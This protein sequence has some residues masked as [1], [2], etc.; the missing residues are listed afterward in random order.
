M[1]YASGLVVALAAIVWSAWRAGRGRPRLLLAGEVDTAPQGTPHAPREEGRHAERDE[2]GSYRRVGRLAAL[3]IAAAVGVAILATHAS[4]EFQAAAFFGA[5]SLVLAACLM[6]VR[7]R[8]R[9]GATG[10]AV[11]LGRGNLVRLAMRNAARNPLRSTL[12]IGLVAAASFLIVAVS[13]FRRDPAQEKPDRASGNGGFTIVAESDQPIYHDFST[14][15]GREQ[16]GF[17]AEDS[18][19][20]A[21]TRTIQLRVRPGDDASCLNLYRPQQPRILG[22]PRDFIE[23]G[24]FDWAAVASPER[25]DRHATLVLD[26][27][28]VEPS[29]ASTPADNPWQL[30]SLEGPPDNDG[31]PRV[32]VVLEKTTANYSLHLSGVGQTL[33]IHDGSGRPVRLVIVG[34][35]AASLFQGDLLVSERAFL[36]YFPEQGGFRFFLVETKSDDA[37]QVQNVQR[38]LERTLGDFGLSTQ[39]TSQRLAAFQAVENT[40]LSTFQSLG[41]LGLLLGTFG[42]GAVQLRSVLERRRELALLRA[43]GFR[44]R[45]LAGMVVLENAILLA[46][47]LACGVVSAAVAVLPHL[48]TGAA[49]IPWTSLAGT[50]GL[51]LAVGLLAGLAAVRS[52]LHAPLLAALRLHCRPATVSG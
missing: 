38:I 8:L 17:S 21:G 36:Q 51:V 4:D 28:E 11:A 41:G 16:L 34:L 45:T 23:R 12:T 52:A 35:L 9:G 7:A 20:L 3:G 30:L 15:E 1:G 50:L 24:G 49:A 22:V 39:T 43:T 47:G 37:A 18:Q 40:Y 33:D 31:V 27:D 2:Y 46:T 48:W 10:P 26:L 19:A 44:R 13:A 25:F 32:P 42:L 5:A 6:G 14:P 29:K